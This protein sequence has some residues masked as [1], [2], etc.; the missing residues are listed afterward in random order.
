V[1]GYVCSAI[2]KCLGGADLCNAGG[3]VGY[4]VSTSYACCRERCL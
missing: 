1:C 4:N 3:D 2:C